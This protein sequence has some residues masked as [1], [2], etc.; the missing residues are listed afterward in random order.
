MSKCI[1][2]VDDEKDIRDTLRDACQNAG[3]E[4]QE[5]EDGQTAF[6]AYQVKP[7]DLIISDLYMPKMNGVHLVRSIRRVNREAK[8]ILI[9]GQSLYNQLK[10]DALS[11]PDACLEKP[12][13]PSL[14]LKA[15]EGLIGAA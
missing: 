14:M 11:C 4:T 7:P 9:S 1:L 13:M 8:I 5:A 3:Y 12:I 15:I 6:L 2:I 10:Y